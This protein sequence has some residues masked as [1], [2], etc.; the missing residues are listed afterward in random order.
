VGAVASTTLSGTLV[1]AVLPAASITVTVM[2]YWPGLTV[3]PATGFCL[4]TN[5]LTGVQLS[6][7]TVLGRTLGT[8]AWQLAS[9]KSVIGPGA[10]RMA[11][12]VAS[13]TLRGV[14]Q[15][16]VFPEA[17]VA[18]TV[19]RCCPGATVVPAVGVWFR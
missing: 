7:A 12:P 4:R 14:L 11:G 1:L 3:V 9:A 8:A 13:T 2:V 18:V 10:L 5:W 19:I 16:A 17:S 6:A 15:V